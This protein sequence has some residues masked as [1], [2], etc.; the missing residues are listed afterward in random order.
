MSDMNKLENYSQDVQAL[1]KSLLRG[2]D[3]VYLTTDSDNYTEVSTSLMITATP[4]ITN[5]VTI[6]AKDVF[7]PEQQIINYVEE[8]HDYPIQYKGCRDHQTL[9][10]S[11]GKKLTAV[12][13]DNQDLVLT[14]L[15]RA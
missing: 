1:A 12:F 10:K 14:I 6:H 15:E 9:S 2:Y 4:R 13:N 7:T 3:T 8:F 11:I 5:T